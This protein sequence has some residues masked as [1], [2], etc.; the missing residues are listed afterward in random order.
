MRNYLKKLPYFLIYNYPQKKNRYFKV[1]EKDYPEWLNEYINTKELLFQN[2]GIQDTSIIENQNTTENNR[3]KRVADSR[4][5]AFF[6]FLGYG[7][8]FQEKHRHHAIEISR[9]RRVMKNKS[10][11]K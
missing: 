7:A 8:I 4:K 6:E 11:K 10:V 2:H 1:L 5:S 3:C 9:N